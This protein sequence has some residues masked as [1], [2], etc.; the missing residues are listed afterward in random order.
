MSSAD[1]LD[2]TAAFDDSSSKLDSFE[3]QVMEAS[4]ADFNN[5]LRETG[6][7]SPQKDSTLV[8]L[9]KTFPDGNF[10]ISEYSSY[11]DDTWILF[12]DAHGA[13]TRIH[14]PETCENHRALKK[15][16]VFNSLPD[17]APFSPIRSFKTTASYAARFNLLVRHVFEPNFL[18]VNPNS[19]KLITSKLLNNSMD[20]IKSTSYKAHG[21]IFF[22]IRFWISLST[23][24][25]IPE[26]F[27]LNINIKTFDTPERRNDILQEFVGNISSWKPFTEADL[28]S[29]MD[30]ARFWTEAALPKLLKTCSYIK[31]NLIDQSYAST[32]VIAEDNLEVEHA[33]SV[34]V[35]G[36][37]L[38][39]PS[40]RRRTYFREDRNGFES[41]TS[42]AWLYSYAT[43]LDHVRNAI[44]ILV[45]LMT[46]LRASEIRPLKFSDLI[47][48]NDGEFSLRIVRYKTADDPN[49]GEIDFIP[50]PRFVGEKIKEMQYLRSVKRLENKNYIFQSCKGRREIK[51][52]SRINLNIM[53]DE[54]S[55]ETKVDRI[56]VHRF[57]KTI[58]EI[59]INRSER[60]IDIIRL[61]FGHKSYAMTL[62]YIGRNPY[63]VRSVAFAIE[64]NYTAEFTDLI[65]SIRSEASSGSS[66]MKIIERIQATENAFVGKQLRITILTYVTH[67]LS[68]GEPLFIHRTAVGTYCISAQRYS[69]PNVPPC[70]SG[71]TEPVIDMLPEPTRCDSSCEHAVFVKKAQRALE[72]NLKFYETILE[73][74]STNL[75]SRAQQ[76]IRRKIS[77]HCEHIENL[78]LGKLL[79]PTKQV[80]A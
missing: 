74:G 52:A 6:G 37:T 60:N 7:D 44:F 51:L 59:L 27:H 16:L 23:Q 13:F 32:Y 4:I 43:S 25:L 58:A 70:L 55:F 26:I 24:N 17:H 77:S 36:K 18:D 45:A 9:L 50:L 30:Y 67:L 71:R 64:Q 35:N 80:E 19:I 49:I 12:K 3:N 15:A 76:M 61:L 72:D 68:A 62:R 20:N 29:M 48:N 10:P 8:K 33:L 46:G 2:P 5:L 38:V 78:K 1:N 54:I 11:K 69:T 34:E 65:N 28:G 39:R 41:Y 14:F 73:K 40:V 47:E 66:A 53:L 42:Y 57:R 63:L 75:S 31:E 56:H 21:D 22:F 79:I